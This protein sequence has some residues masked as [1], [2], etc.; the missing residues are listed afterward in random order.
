MEVEEQVVQWLKDGRDDAQDIVD[1]PWIVKKQSE[2][3]YI[4]E[5]PKMPFI[6]NIL[7]SEGF[8][9]LMVPFG[10]E[11]I[12]LPLEERLKIYH[13]MLVL[14]DRINLLKF[15]L[16]GINDEVVLRVDLDKKTL[17]KA[18]FNDALVALLIG[19]NEL[20]KAL[21][22]EEDFAKAVFERV[23]LMILERLE[24]GATREELIKFLIVKVGM[25]KE[26]AEKFI[27]DIL[28]SQGLSKESADVG[29]F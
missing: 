24:S 22:L 17:G 18:E 12:V 8:V 11:T 26:E 1:L 20:V 15:T 25:P 23:V 27:D 2:H 10:V 9:H 5:H 6:L 28:K 19:M 21:G 4:A 14:N 13:T 16:S 3:F 7:F 29:Y